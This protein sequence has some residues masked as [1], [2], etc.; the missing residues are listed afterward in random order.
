M[1]SKRILTLA[2]AGCFMLVG[3]ASAGTIDLYS[4][5][6]AFGAYNAGFGICG[7]CG[8][9]PGA[10][11][12]VQFT[13][14]VNASFA[15]AQ[16]ALQLGSGTNQVTVDV[17]LE[18]DASGV[19]SGINLDSISVT[20][21]TPSPGSSLI[22]ATSISHPSLVAGS[23]YWLLLVETNPA[24][25]GWMVNS[26]GDV[27]TSTDLLVGIDTTSG[28]WVTDS[29]I[30]RPAFQIDGT[31]EPGTIVLLGAGLIALGL[32]GKLRSRR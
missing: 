23:L 7:A 27:A 29:G 8:P 1:P 22:T 26:T 4:N 3:G 31:P 19:P 30:T 16:I 25:V 12:A 14:S 20:G 13:P 24:Q 18:A 10:N 5:L 9:P 15:D 17:D 11:I 6:G 32:T 28:P 21:L 2:A